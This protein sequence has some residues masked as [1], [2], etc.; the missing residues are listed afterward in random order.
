MHLKKDSKNEKQFC[1]PKNLININV[2]KE[3]IADR[4]EKQ[5]K[6]KI[7]S[8]IQ[9]T[10]KYKDKHLTIYIE[11]VFKSRLQVL[12]AIFTTFAIF[13]IERDSIERI[14]QNK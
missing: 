4:D 5:F 10:I 3:I 1:A 11:R 8:C 7:K 14:N 2:E 12:K 13:S 9:Y 6:K